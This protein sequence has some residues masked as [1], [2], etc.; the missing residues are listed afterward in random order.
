MEVPVRLSMAW[1]TSE[2]WPSYTCRRG[3]R[4]SASVGSWDAG[5]VQQ[6]DA[7]ALLQMHAACDAIQEAG[8]LL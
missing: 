2:F 7:A 6:W 8:P 5:Q 3:G 1:N 4:G